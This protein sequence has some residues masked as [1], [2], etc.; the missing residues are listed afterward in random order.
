MTTLRN[1]YIIEC[2]GSV[3]AVIKEKKLGVDT[4]FVKFL[5]T[6]GKKGRK[7]ILNASAL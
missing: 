3:L 2:N 4:C 6:T 5:Y 1:I 7:T